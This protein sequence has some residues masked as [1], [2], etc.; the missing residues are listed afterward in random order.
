MELVEAYRHVQKLLII[1]GI[2]FCVPILG[3]AL[4]LRDPVLISAQNIVDAEDKEVK[5]YYGY[6]PLKWEFNGKTVAQYLG[7]KQN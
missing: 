7:L 5:E 1:V 4:F 2:C 6:N 3:F